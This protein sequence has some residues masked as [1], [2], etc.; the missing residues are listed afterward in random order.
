M[1]G[2][3]Q[4]CHREDAVGSYQLA[5]QHER[6]VSSWHRLQVEHYRGRHD[7]PC[8][9]DLHAA[10]RNT[11]FPAGPMLSHLNAGDMHKLRS[12][13]AGQGRQGRAGRGM[14]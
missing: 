5:Q 4:S 9:V 7:Y 3:A 13:H 10:Q 11:G 8:S 6:W 2:V 12:G 14:A 1:L